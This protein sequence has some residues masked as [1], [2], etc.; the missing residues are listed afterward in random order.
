MPLRG[1][2]DATGDDLMTDHL[3]AFDGTFLELEDADASAHMHIGGILVFGPP[4]ATVEE[5]RAAIYPRLDAL[6]RY[7]RRL[8]G[9]GAGTLRWQRWV[10][11]DAFDITRHVIEAE[12]PAP[13]GWEQLLDWA[14]GYF[15]AR[16]PRDRPLWEIAVVDGLP[17]PAPAGEAHGGPSLIAGAAHLATHPLELAR[18]T[19]ALAEL[20]V[21]EEI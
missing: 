19:A 10:D 9:S 14:G 12:V 18:R 20:A 21:R 1:D 17:M 7:R 16:L 2:R 6:P 8:A 3:T 15:S 13:G 5:V 11:D 4:A